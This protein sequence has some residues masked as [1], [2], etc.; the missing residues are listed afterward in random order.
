MTDSSIT[1]LSERRFRDERAGQARLPIAVDAARA[2]AA[3][4]F[5]GA[6]GEPPP[7]QQG[8]RLVIA[9][10]CSD[11]A[12]EHT[13]TEAVFFALHDKLP[14]DANH[15]KAMALG[16]LKAASPQIYQRV[17]DGLAAA[18]IL[19]R[20]QDAADQ[21]DANAAEKLKLLTTPARGVADAQSESWRPAHEP[22]S[23]PRNK[24]TH[25]S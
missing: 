15:R 2:A 12:S 3:D 9:A 13:Q 21:G 8:V 5:F 11:A 7:G 24:D 4:A 1:N 10:T 6:L 14:V 20:L 19:E 22:H 17:L 23:P 16:T 25:S 18:E